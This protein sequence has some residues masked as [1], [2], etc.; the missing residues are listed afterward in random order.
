MELL[1]RKHKSFSSLQEPISSRTEVLLQRLHRIALS[2]VRISASSPVL[3]SVRRISV[4]MSSAI[5]VKGRVYTKSF[6][7]SSSQQ[8][9]R[10]DVRQSVFEGENDHAEPSAKKRPIQ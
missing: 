2:F 3:L 7:M 10:T 8:R 4:R 6:M 5:C 1:L 9:R